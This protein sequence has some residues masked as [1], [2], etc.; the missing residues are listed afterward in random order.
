MKKNTWLKLLFAFFGLVGSVLAFLFAWSRYGRY[1]PGAI[2]KAG[3]IKQH[4]PDKIM[5]Y[6][7]QVEQ[8]VV[9]LAKADAKGVVERWKKRFGK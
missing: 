3:D 6:H 9:D 5:D 4:T 8:G 1:I 7:R 2:K